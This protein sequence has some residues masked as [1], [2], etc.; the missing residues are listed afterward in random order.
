M[1]TLKK[2]YQLFHKSI[3][4]QLFLTS[5]SLPF[6]LAWG[7]PFSIMSP[8]S[9][10]IFGPFLS[11][12]LLISSLIFFSEL[13]YLPN[14]ILIWLLEKVTAFWFWCL[15]M[16]QKTWL[17]GFSKPPLIILLCIPLAA[18]AIIHTKKIQSLAQR[19]LLLALF[20][21]GTCGS[22]KLL[23]FHHQLIEKI[24]CNKGE[25]TLINHPHSLILI[26]PAFLAARPSYESLIAYGILPEIIQK[27]GRLHIDH[28]IIG[29]FNKR[30]LD[31]LTFLAT[32]VGIGTIYLPFWK[33]K[34]PSFAWK[35]FKELKKTVADNGGKIVSV[36]YKK[37]I[38]IDEQSII[39]IK[40]IETKCISY[41]D[42][43]YQP[44]SIEGSINSKTISL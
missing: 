32:K 30:I 4:L 33:G 15:Q 13:L 43:T 1:S 5:I 44:I 10:L 39:I 38:K 26:D 11:L 6:L 31:A 27:T 35:S 3:Q 42:A 23:Q 7:L 37:Q 21:I 18:L 34:I 24:P 36:S 17:I 19:T 25:L 29:K 9:T 40:P 12:F 2:W 8:F 14:S 22:L 41:Y 16:K 28:L 20:L